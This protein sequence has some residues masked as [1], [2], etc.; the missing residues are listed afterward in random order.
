MIQSQDSLAMIRKLFFQGLLV[1]CCIAL[2]GQQL[3]DGFIL[4]EIATGLN[5]THMALAPDNRIYITEKHGAVRVVE[6]DVLQEQA[7]LLL[8]VEDFN[9]RG[10][11][12]L[13]FQKR[14]L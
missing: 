4:E 9:E 8:E 12:G 13:A 5:P 14:P 1:H 2:S 11:Q 6:N 10:L 7:Y 3:P